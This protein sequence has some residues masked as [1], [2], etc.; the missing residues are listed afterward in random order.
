MA[1]MTPLV[2]QSFPEEF[3]KAQDL[4]PFASEADIANRILIAHSGEITF[5][6]DV[7]EEKAVN[8]TGFTPKF[9]KQLDALGVTQAELLEAARFTGQ[10]PQT[11]AE[12]ASKLGKPKAE[13]FYTPGVSTAEESDV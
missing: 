1:D 6:K 9:L 5:A 4:D 12:K 10:T 3:K 8:F 11:Y 2:K 13:Q 7:A